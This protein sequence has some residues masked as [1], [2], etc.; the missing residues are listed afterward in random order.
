MIGKTSYDSQ[1]RTNQIETTFY[2]FFHLLYNGNFQ[3]C[4]LKLHNHEQTHNNQG[5]HFMHNLIIDIEKKR[6]KSKL[7]K[8]EK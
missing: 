1:Y 3:N 2:G 4:T 5:H 7:S 6:K 8:I